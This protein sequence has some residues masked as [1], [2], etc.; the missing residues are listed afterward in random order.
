MTEIL[1]VEDDPTASLLLTSFLET[2]N[3]PSRAVENGHDAIEY[4]RNNVVD[5]VLLDLG[6]PDIK[7]LDLIQK[8]QE[9]S[10]SAEIIVVTGESSADVAL[11]A[12]RLGAKDYI[13]KPITAERLLVTVKNISER[14]E[15][16]RKIA[17]LEHEDKLQKNFKDFIG[18]SNVMQDVYRA[19]EAAAQSSENVFI[20]GEQ[21]VGKKLCAKSIHSLSQRGDQPFIV[22]DCNLLDE[23]ES[24]ATAELRDALVKAEGGTCYL[25]H[26]PALPEQAQK[27]L[28]KFFEQKHDVRLICSSRGAA[29]DKVKSGHLREDLY[30]RLN[31]LPITLPPLRER[32]EDIDLI[33]SFYLREYARDATKNFEMFNANALALL[34]S[35]H[36]PGNVRELQ[37]VV[38]SIVLLNQDTKVVTHRMIPKDIFEGDDSAAGH[39]ENTQQKTTVFEGKDIIPIPDLEKMAIE[40]A[41]KVCNGN[42]QEA[43]LRLKISPATLY[44]KKPQKEQP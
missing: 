4:L 17:S 1:I 26:I 2:E 22:V 29:L 28:M 30:Y 43:S 23:E 13:V 25:A 33:A 3:I 34:R 5:I 6:L 15:L 18:L 21:G 27:M 12:I 32:G 35:F 10:T 37:N 20:H 31:I 41:L 40:H 9:T 16:N 39:N 42:V 14:I 44:R 11:E 7:G 36:W 8:V 38:K 24:D 19:I